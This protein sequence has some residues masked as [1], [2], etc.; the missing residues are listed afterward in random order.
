[1]ITR[2]KKKKLPL[3]IRYI[4]EA[5]KRIF[6]IANQPGI[7]GK[8]RKSND[9]KIKRADGSLLQ[10][11]DWVKVP[12]DMAKLDAELRAITKNAKKAKNLPRKQFNMIL[13]LPQHPR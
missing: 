10:Y 3:E 2:L 6:D 9:I 13:L 1:M 8:Y 5:H 12:E 7:A 4:N 11:T